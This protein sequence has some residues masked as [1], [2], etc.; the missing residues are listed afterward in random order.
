VSVA[1]LSTVKDP[2]TVVEAAALVRRSLDEARFILVGE[3]PL[4]SRLEERVKQ[5]RLEPNVRLTGVQPDVRHFLAAADIGLLASLSEGSSNAL[6]EYMAMGLP[7]AVSDIPANRELVAGVF[8]E[9]GNPAALAEKILDLW[10]NAALR[11]R[12]SQGNLRRG[13]EFS[14]ENFALRAQAFYARLAAE[15]LD[16]NRQY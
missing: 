16:R 4:R 10:G 9:P 3:G 5:L 13:K 6:L 8:F 15:H 14:E 11:A 7:V 12:M 2:L 1:N